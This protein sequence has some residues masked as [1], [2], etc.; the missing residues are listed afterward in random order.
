MFSVAGAV[1]GSCAGCSEGL[2]VL[3]AGTRVERTSIERTRRQEG[4]SAA[5]SMEGH[6]S[7]IHAGWSQ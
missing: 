6:S 3:W 1:F 4:A 2:E 7:F 5:A